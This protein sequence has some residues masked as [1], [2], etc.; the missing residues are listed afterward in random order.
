[1]PPVREHPAGAGDV[2][3]DLPSKPRPDPRRMG[4]LAPAPGA[5]LVIKG[6]CR[7]MVTP[8]QAALPSRPSSFA[9]AAFQA[10]QATSPLPDPSAE[11][12]G[13][14]RRLT[15][16]VGMSPGKTPRNEKTPAPSRGGLCFARGYWRRPARDKHVAIPVETCCPVP[17]S[18][19]W[20]GVGA[21]QEPGQHASTARKC[22][23]PPVPMVSQGHVEL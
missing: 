1:Q 11:P 15:G 2:F 14:A 19:R 22:I 21:V 10:I 12:G 13:P 5:L 8:S 9:S 4:G 23:P 3:A 6:G 20:R 18:Q 17:A 16:P 7:W